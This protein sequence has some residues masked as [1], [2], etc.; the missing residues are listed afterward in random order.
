MNVGKWG[1]SAPPFAGI[2][3]Y[4]LSTENLQRPAGEMLKE[5][6]HATRRPQAIGARASAL[7]SPPVALVAIIAFTNPIVN[8]FAMYMQLNIINVD[9]HQVV[10]QNPDAKIESAKRFPASRPTLTSRCH[11]SNR[12]R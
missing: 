7:G 6:R 10:L 2:A 4:A 8:E 9:R 1:R 5:G 3:A 12:L 11:A